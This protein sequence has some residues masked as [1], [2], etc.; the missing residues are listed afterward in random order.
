FHFGGRPRSI[1][2]FEVI[3]EEI[4]VVGVVPGIAFFRR[5]RLGRLLGLRLFRGLE[6]LRRH[7]L[8][9]RILHHFLVQKIGQFQRRHRQ[10]LDGLLERWRQDELLNELG[11]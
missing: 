3:P 8:E 10:Q 1:V 6:L 5:R 2:V 9:Q 7:F 4:F 11:V